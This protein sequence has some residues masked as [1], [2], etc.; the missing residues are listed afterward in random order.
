VTK[1]VDARQSAVITVACF[2][3][4]ISPLFKMDPSV[5]QFPGRC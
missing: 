1:D 3:D 4:I 5:Q 2:Q